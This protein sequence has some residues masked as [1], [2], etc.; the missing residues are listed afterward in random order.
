MCRLLAAIIFINITMEMG[1]GW[2]QFHMDEVGMGMLL[3]LHVSL[4]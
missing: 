2:G 3:Y 1:M 4:Y